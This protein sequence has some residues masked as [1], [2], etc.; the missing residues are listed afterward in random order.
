MSAMILL[1]SNNYYNCITDCVTLFLLLFN[2]QF[3]CFL[4]FLNLSSGV[5]VL[6]HN[7]R[8]ILVHGSRMRMTTTIVAF[9]II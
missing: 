5:C 2:V 1:Y 9:V 4:K 3:H 6:F 8:T 7:T